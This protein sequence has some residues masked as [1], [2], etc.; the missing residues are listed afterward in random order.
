MKKFH[1][2]RVLRHVNTLFTNSGCRKSRSPFIPE[3][4]LTADTRKERKSQSACRDEM[5]Q[6][7]ENMVTATLACRMPSGQENRF[8]QARTASLP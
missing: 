6:M 2:F 4:N 7:E 3:S 1:F 5:R 8:A